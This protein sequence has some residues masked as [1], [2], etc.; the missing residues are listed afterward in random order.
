[1]KITCLSLL[2]LLSVLLTSLTAPNVNKEIP[3]VKIGT[4]VWSS[5]NLDVT[6]FRNGDPIFEANTF[7]KW[8]QANI[9]GRPA[10]CYYEND[11]KNG[12]LYGKLYNYWAVSDKRGLAPEGWHIPT[13]AEWTQLAEFLGS[14]VNAGAGLKSSKG[15]SA[16]PG[17][18]KTGFN[19][20]PGGY[21]T[22]EGPRYYGGPFFHKGKAGYWWSSTRYLV[23]NSFCRILS[24]KNQ[25]LAK[26]HFVQ[27]SGLS[28][29]L[30]KD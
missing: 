26:D 2:A 1:M 18:N 11:P 25:E 24:V 22:H 4:Q 21:R 29:R 10:W 12:E 7:E 9:E 5:K 17:T 30:I 8:E 19:A 20:L 15:W 13:D 6:H 3:S 27:M 16:N 28:V 14:P 23:D